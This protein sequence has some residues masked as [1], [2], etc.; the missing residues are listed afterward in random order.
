LST[1]LRLACSLLS[2]DTESS[3]G[4]ACGLGLLTSNLVAPEVSQTSVSSDL[5]ESLQVLSELGINTVRDELRPCALTDISLSIEEPLGNVVV[6]GLGKNV[7]DLIN[8]LFLQFSS[9]IPS[10]MVRMIM[11]KLNFLLPLVKVDLS[12]LE[13]E[14][15]ES[16]ANTLD[17]SQGKHGLALSLDVCVLDSE[18]VNE[19]F[20][21]DQVERR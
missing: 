15:G 13:D 5:L 1:A 4:S 20:S 14:V 11:C 12:D 9:S 10:K 21:L 18:N 6:S 19:L 3:S 16:S 7:V 2:G 17:S 8:V